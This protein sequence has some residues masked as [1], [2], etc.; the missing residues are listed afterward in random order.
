MIHLEILSS[1]DA[2]AV[3]LYDFEYDEIYIGRSKKNDL[4]F[5]DKELP[6]NFMALQIIEEVNGLFLVARSFTRLPFFFL[7]GK[8]ISGA[9]KIYPNDIIAFGD[10]QIKIKSFKQTKVEEDLSLAFDNFSQ[11]APELRF[12][13]DFIEEVLIDS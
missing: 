1:S 4:I 5:L 6:L 10:N 9:L 7:N 2:N 3:G 8:K 12:A 13:L 11:K